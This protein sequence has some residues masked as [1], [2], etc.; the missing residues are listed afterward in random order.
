MINFISSFLHETFFPEIIVALFFNM[1]VLLEISWNETWPTIR[2]ISR[3]V[4]MD[5]SW[6]EV[7]DVSRVG[8]QS[9]FLKNA[10]SRDPWKFRA[11]L[12]DA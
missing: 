1:N 2:I 8:R 9:K 6:A 4:S 11:T 10:L 3:H 7:N 12:S 5:S